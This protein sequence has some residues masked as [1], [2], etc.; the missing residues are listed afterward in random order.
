MAVIGVRKRT[1][2]PVSEQRSGGE[3]IYNPACDRFASILFVDVSV[4]QLGELCGERV[5]VGEA[6]Q[7]E[8]ERVVLYAS[9]HRNR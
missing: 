5:F 2:Y 9:N 3:L 4:T 7:I 6:A 8:D 1:P